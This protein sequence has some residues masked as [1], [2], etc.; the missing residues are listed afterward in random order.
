LKRFKPGSKADDKHQRTP[1]KP[2][3]RVKGSKKNKPGS[4]STGTGKITLS[5]ATI[6][7]LEN[8][9]K[10]HNEKNPNKRVTLGK[11]KAVWRRGAGA[12]SGSHRPGMSRA[13]WSM[14]RVNAFLYKVRN[15]RGKDPKYVQDDDLLPKRT[16]KSL[17]F[18]DV[19]RKALT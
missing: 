7:G 13:Q 11:L 5:A 3:E 10:E 15:G 6:K 1:A 17:T 4:A 8:K 12:F 14:G 16:K 2:S 19:V 9:V 18:S